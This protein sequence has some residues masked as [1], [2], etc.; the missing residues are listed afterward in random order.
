MDGKEGRREGDIHV[1]DQ[2]MIVPLLRMYH[3]LRIV[4]DHV[5][6]LTMNDYIATHQETRHNPAVISNNANI[7][8]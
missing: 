5:D 3:W 2:Q 6:S 7:I 1:I 4:H 8:N